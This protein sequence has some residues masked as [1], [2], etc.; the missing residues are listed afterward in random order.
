MPSARSTRASVR[1]AGPAPTMPTCVRT[2]SPLLVL[3][4]LRD[5]ERRVGRRDT[6]V[7]GALEQHLLDVVPR[8]A[9]P[10]RRPQVELELPLAAERHHRGQRDQAARAPVEARPRPDLAPRVPGEELLEL[11]GEGGGGCIRRV[12]V[13]VAVHLAAHLHAAFV[14][15]VGH[16]VSPA[17][18]S[19]TASANAFGWLALARWAQSSRTTRRASGIPSASSWPRSGGA[20]VSSAPEMTSVGAKTR[21]SC[22]VASHS[23]RASQQPA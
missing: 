9:D 10:A 16:P 15:L 1:P 4:A 5:G 21:R 23:A 20:T 2:A 18:W 19:S 7:D 17:R 22:G 8:H 11:A 13:L 12:H 14:A 6:A 3:H